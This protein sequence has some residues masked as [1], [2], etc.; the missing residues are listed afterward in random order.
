MGLILPRLTRDVDCEGMGYPGIVLTFWL[1]VDDEKWT[2]PQKPEPPDDEG[3]EADPWDRYAYWEMSRKIDQVAVP[4]EYL[5]DSSV[6]V[7]YEILDCEAAYD[8]AN[9]E[10]SDILLWAVSAYA[11][12]RNEW[13]TSA[14]KN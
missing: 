10:F 9:G 13:L 2:P 6:D 11:Q 7:I 8:L 3:W 5:D 12:Q 4:A 1:N 14:V